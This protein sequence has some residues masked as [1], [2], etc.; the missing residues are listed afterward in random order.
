MKKLSKLA[1]KNTQKER[2]TR[3]KKKKEGTDSN[4]SIN[5]LI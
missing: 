1:I 3:Q 2:K 5:S 4:Y